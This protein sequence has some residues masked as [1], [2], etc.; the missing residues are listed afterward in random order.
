[1]SLIECDRLVVA[2]RIALLWGFEEQSDQNPR[3]YVGDRISLKT[4]YPDEIFFPSENIYLCVLLVLK[5]ILG[6]KK[7][8]LL[9][10]AKMS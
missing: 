5:P 9:P 8:L 2:C 7:S 10:R 3:E 6:S 4:L 1:M